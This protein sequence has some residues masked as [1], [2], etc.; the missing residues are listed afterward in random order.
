MFKAGVA[1]S[2]KIRAIQ[3]GKDACQKAIEKIGGQADLIIAFSSVAYDQQELVQGLQQAAGRTP[4]IGCSDSGEI[5]NQGPTSGKVAVMALQTPDI[6]YSFGIGRGTDKNSFEAGKQAAQQVKD[7]AKHDLSLFIM[8]LDGLAENGAAAVRGVQEVLGENFPI[9]GGSAG[10]DFRFKKTYQY[11]NG[12]VL[13]NSIVGVGL[14][15]NFSFG[16]GVKHGW[17]P[18]G[19]PMKVTKSKGSKLIEINGRPALSIYEDYFGKKAEELIKEPI[20]KIAYTYPLGLSVEGSDELLIRDVVIANKKGEITCAAEIPEGSEVRLMLGDPDKAINS[21][22]EAAKHAR[23][24]LEEEGAQPKAAII[25]DCMARCKLLGQGI[26]N[27]E[28]IDAIK[29]VLPDAEII[30]FYTYGEQAPL[31]GMLGEKCR[32]VFHNETMTMLVLGE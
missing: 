2:S 4:V 11:F 5:T 15:G 8:L 9:M 12:E 19:L 16:V 6:R 7:N 3:A 31:A 30:G 17:E 1:T 27:K 22:R 13:T 29:E 21:A 28:E 10:D 24:Q 20:A 23:R 18:I 14:S 25:F 26:R 32:S